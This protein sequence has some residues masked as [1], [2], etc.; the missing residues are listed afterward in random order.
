MGL[1]DSVFFTC[2]R[3]EHSLEVQSKMGEC[4][5]AS[6]DPDRVPVA[7]AQDILGETVWC[8]NCDQTWSVCA[9]NDIATVKM[10]LG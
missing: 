9:V 3:C 8:G 2:P 7:I 5:L 4:V 10:R 1:F 6:I